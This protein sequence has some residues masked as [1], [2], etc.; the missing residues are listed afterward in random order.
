MRRLI[1]ISGTNLCCKTKVLRLRLRN[2][3]LQNTQC[4]RYIRVQNNIEEE[5]ISRT[6]VMYTNMNKREK[7]PGKSLPYFTKFTLRTTLLET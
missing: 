4:K 7:K 3:T 6:R 2:M 1:Y 5:M